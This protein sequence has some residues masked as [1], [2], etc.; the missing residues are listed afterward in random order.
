MSEIM[1]IIDKREMKKNKT[2]NKKQKKNKDRKRQGGRSYS[3]RVRAKW[4]CC[5]FKL[6]FLQLIC[7][8]I[9]QS[10]LLC[11]SSIN[12]PLINLTQVK[13]AEDEITQYTSANYTAILPLLQKRSSFLTTDWLS[14]SVSSHSQ[15]FWFQRSFKASSSSFEP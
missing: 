14:S 13:S 6:G 15:P 7:K 1:K 8:A 11:T 12:T 9:L 2:K 10:T 5:A 4:F 3:G